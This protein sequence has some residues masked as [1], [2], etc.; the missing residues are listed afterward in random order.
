[1][2]G[3]QSFNGSQQIADAKEIAIATILT[4]IA[5]SFSSSSHCFSS[6]YQHLRQPFDPGQVFV[7]CSFP[8]TQ[9][10]PQQGCSN[11]AL[12]AQSIPALV[13]LWL[14]HL[15]SSVILSS[16][17]PA[18]SR[19]SPYLPCLQQRQCPKDRQRTIQAQT[20]RTIARPGEEK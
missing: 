17:R 12:Q 15:D 2:Q 7:F 6:F 3:R 14:L 20:R 11:L 8:L 13:Q 4:F 18:P 5:C 19:P 10:H 1:L 16:E 9:C